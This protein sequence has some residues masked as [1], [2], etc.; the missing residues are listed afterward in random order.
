MAHVRERERGDAC[1]IKRGACE[2]DIEVHMR[3][4]ERH[5]RGRSRGTH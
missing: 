3:D 5:M 2:S 4:S 1:E